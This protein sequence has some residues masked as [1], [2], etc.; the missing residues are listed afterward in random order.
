MRCQ[1]GWVGH[2]VNPSILQAMNT[3]LS[4]LKPILAAATLIAVTLPLADNAQASLVLTLQ[5]GVTT[6][7]VV[8]NGVGDL[9]PAVGMIVF[10]GAV[11]SF[12]MNMSGGYGI[13]AAVEPT[14]LNLAGFTMS[15]GAGTLVLTLEEDGYVT[16]SP[17]ARFI[18][19]VGGTIG[20]GTVTNRSYIDA[21]NTMG[22][23]GAMLADHGTDSAMSFSSDITSPFYPVSGAYGL[24]VKVTIEHLMAGSTQYTNQIRIDEPAA[25]GLFGLSL[26]GMGLLARR[27][28]G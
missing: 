6:T 24:A 7:T 21:S 10:T 13:G 28:R 17:Q 14:L 1:S 8:D 18:S 20:T 11:G 15:S 25:L 23:M 4:V 22:V 12:N 16:T 26:V 9:D 27:R 5:S 19:S 3:K 2:S